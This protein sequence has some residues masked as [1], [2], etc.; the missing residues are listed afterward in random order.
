MPN[1]PHPPFPLTAMLS[2]VMNC[3]HSRC[4]Y[5]LLR[6]PLLPRLLSVLG[7]LCALCA[8][9]PAM[10]HGT[11]D[12][13]DVG[14]GASDGPLASDTLGTALVTRQRRTAPWR[15]DVSVQRMDSAALRLRGVSDMADALRRFAGVNLRDYGGAGAM[16]TLS[17][18]GLGAAHTAVS[19]DGMPVSEAQGGQVDLSRYTLGGISALTLTTGGADSLLVPVSALAAA[20]LSL[21]PHRGTP[22]QRRLSATLTTGAFGHLSP[23]LEADMP[24]GADDMLTVAAEAAFAQNNYPFTLYNGIATERLRRNHSRTDDATADAAWTHALSGGQWTTRLRYTYS[25]RQLPGPVAYYTERGTAHLQ[26]QTAMGQTMV[27][28]V[29]GAWQMMAGAKYHF[30]ESLY[31]DIDAQYPGGRNDLRYRQ[32]HG[33]ATAGVQRS[34]GPWQVAAVM[35]GSRQLM[36]GNTA[37]TRRAERLAWL[38]HLSL[39]Y[40]AGPLTATARLTGHHYF[41]HRMQAQAQHDVHRLTPSAALSLTLIDSRRLALMLRAN[42]QEMFRMPTFDEVSR[43]HLG[44]APLR[45]ERTRQAGGSLTLRAMPDL[46]W[47]PVVTLTADAYAARVSDRLLSVPYNLFVWRTANVERVESHGADATVE[48]R[49][50]PQPD[51]RIVLSATYAYL[52]AADRSLPGSTGYGNQLAYTPH[53]SASASLAYDGP[54]GLACLHLTAASARWSTTDHTPTTRL[55]GYAVAGISLSR[56]FTL[57]SV[58]MEARLD[59]T[60]IMDK[61]YAVVR[62]YPMPGRAWMLG[63]KATW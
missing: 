40:A 63:V 60:N 51:H 1:P 21:T 6:P 54:L 31:A 17:V 24:L 41:H 25:L 55:P 52:R 28:R 9:M 33:Y 29:R 48:C 7:T 50:R 12:G 2:V 32:Q 57:G 47:H 13:I 14:V 34:W 30:G 61:D 3:R 46:P 56:P 43:Y 53:H 10:A 42:A 44:S 45:P 62:R 58:R 59:V 20:H 11:T 15:A 37:D 19:Y 36:V 8:P 23:R 5:A 39:R 22:Q 35:D 27:R 38:Q 49:L 16:K 18:R 4:A 26:E